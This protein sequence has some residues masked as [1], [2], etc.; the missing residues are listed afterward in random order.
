MATFI[1]NFRT[2]YYNT[3]HF[4]LTG[5]HRQYLCS[6]KQR[7]SVCENLRSNSI[8]NLCTP[9]TK[10]VKESAG[11]RLHHISSVE[12]SLCNSR[13]FSVW[14]K[15]FLN[16][17][18]RALSVQR[19]C[20]RVYSSQENPGDSE[21]G[22]DNPSWQGS[23]SQYLPTPL[24]VPDY[25]PRVPVLAVN[26][27][28]V[29]PKFSKMLE[30]KDPE[31]MELLRR[32]VRLNQPYAGVFLK[33]SDSNEADCVTSLD[34]IYKIGTFVQIAELQDMKTKVRLIVNCHRRI[35][36]TEVLPEDA[37]P[38]PTVKTVQEKNDSKRKMKRRKNGKNNNGN[39]EEKTEITEVEEKPIE[40][41]N[42]PTPPPMGEKID[43][44]VVKPVSS[45]KILMVETEN[46]KDQSYE[47]S[48]QMK[49]TTAAVVETIRDIISLNPIYRENLAY[50]IQHNRFNDNPVYISDLGA[51]LTAAE[52]SDLQ[53]VLEE[54]DVSERLHMVL[55]LLKKEFERNKLQKKIGEEVEEKVRKQHRDFILRE[56]LKLIKKELGME[57]DDKDA[58]AEKFKARLEGLEVPDPIMEV[59]NEELTKLSI[60][61]NHSSEFSVTR[62]YLDWLTVLPWG[63]FTEENL[64]LTKAKEILE[65]DH[66]GMKDVK[67]RIMEFIAV[68][69]L[70][71]STQ[72]KILCFQGP[73][74]V[75]KTS[76]AKSIARALGREYY[77]FSVG[78]MYDVSEIKGHRRTYVGAMP[79]KMIQCLKKTKSMNPLVLID[80]VDKI[81]SN[82]LHGDPAAA[83]LE[84]LDPEQNAN[85]LDH[86]L[87]V[88]IDVS[89][90]LFISTANDIGTI[91]DPLL[92]R[93]EVIEVSGYIADEKFQ[94]AQRYLVPQ[95]E[96]NSG[97]KKEQVNIYD[98]ALKTLIHS[99]CRESG[100]RNLQK[101]IEKIY[102]KCA[103]SIAKKE[104][105]K[106]E[107]SDNT[108]KKFIGLPIFQTD[109]MYD[110]TPPGVVTG[111]AWTGYGGTTLYLE[112][113]KLPPAKDQEK[114]GAPTLSV[115]GNMA[116]VMEES[117]K[118][119]YTYS[120]TLL[121]EIDPDNEFFQT[122]SIHLHSPEG[123]TPK[124]G[125]SA[126]IAIT[127]ALMSLAMNRPCR[128]E[129][130]MTGEIT[131]TGKVL[132]IGGLKEK[133][134]AAKRAGMKCVLIP[135]ENRSKFEDLD[136][137]VKS[138][139]EVHFVK[140]YKEV[141][142]IVFPKEEAQS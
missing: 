123:A 41:L 8:R 3:K 12:N 99:Y 48:D 76:I 25:F 22:G 34:D 55:T 108:L 75:G 9:Q 97:I 16:Q 101:H 56:Q 110:V 118:I 14:N 5:S 6:S 33:K 126:G 89:K 46:V 125:P 98:D 130:A 73:P 133:L 88:P 95:A 2:C 106:V 129:V 124:D 105:E 38:F 79:G 11:R 52:S 92:D 100:V 116:K 82:R 91:P 120:K 26:R 134:L 128:Q 19:Q 65:E 7:H 83:L 87:D 69:Q 119:G 121:N 94:I 72:G 39:E 96:T 117:S 136:E 10:T 44:S 29:F 113:V 60:L 142:D 80:E 70:K 107:V 140:H 13:K 50:M 115:T 20:L 54:L 35:K 27:N 64:E 21:D 86:F 37:E 1:R 74:G 112:C 15:C 139:L 49:A 66:Y 90:V 23:Q 127:T 103:L 131:L 114:G 24:T 61:D 17:G 57:K 109:R 40:P 122:S 77:R 47:Y 51:Q 31:L 84:L 132:A 58:I 45:N 85:F 53:S 62:N 104:T 137:A 30:I 28:P 93:M 67:D 18:K 81:G 43:E 36:I 59:I 102:R 78:G 111:L 138:D 42:T 135:E 68:S 32:K 4:G 141:F 71:G 63:K